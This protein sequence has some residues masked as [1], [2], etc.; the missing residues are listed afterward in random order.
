MRRLE[1]KFYESDVIEDRAVGIMLPFNGNAQ[2]VDIRRAYN[3]VPIRD[4]KPFRQ[5]Y[6]TE[7]QAISNL[8]NL[9]LTRKGERLMQPNFG[10]LIPEFVFEQNTLSNRED[11]RFSV[12]E[13]ILFWL[14]YINVK[15]IS[16][17][18]DE[19]IDFPISDTDHS[20]QVKIEFSVTEVGANKVITISLGESNVDVQIN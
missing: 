7:E 2:L 11:L 13:D 6:S 5:S 17:L 8:V 9:L 1:Y 20:V 18:S 19:D 3:Q 12:Q 10:S 15:N 14:P 4:V 16:I